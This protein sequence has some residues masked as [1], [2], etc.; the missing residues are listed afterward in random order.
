MLVR[1]KIKSIDFP[2]KQDVLEYLSEGQEEILNS[3]YNGDKKLQFSCPS[4]GVSHYKLLKTI[5]NGKGAYCRDCSRLHIVSKDRQL[6]ENFP[7]VAKMFDDANNIESYSKRTL[8]SK[9]VTYGSH[10]NY[11]FKCSQGHTFESPVSD[12]VRSYKEGS[13]FLG[14]PYCSGVNT[15]LVPKIKDIIKNA[16]TWW[17]SE[18]NN[19]SIE[20][21]VYKKYSHTKYAWICPKGHS[22]FRSLDKI[23]DNTLT[24]PVCS[25]YKFQSGI[26]DIKTLVPQIAE[27][28]DEE[29]NGIKASEAY[30]SKYSEKDYWWKCSKGHSFLRKPVNIDVNNFTCAVCQGKQVNMGINDLQTLRPDIMKYWV[31]DNDIKPWNITVDSGEIASFYCIQCGG[32]YD[33]TITSRTRSR[34]LCS[35]CNEIYISSQGEEEI[36]DFL[37]SLGIE[38]ERQAH[39]FKNKSKACDFYLPAQNLVIEYNG[40]YWHSEA[41]V[42]ASII[43]ITDIRN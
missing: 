33:T 39:L 23:K 26:N 30:W 24:C 43:I 28:F 27:Y 8:S 9:Q 4:C 19:C 40:I 12:V 17:D 42:K 34:G 6:Y 11:K 2:Y 37:S 1:Q 13:K 22:F 16:D 36:G 38:Y 31:K 25:G 10:L 41:G 7:E 29:K 21:A 20:D 14:C 15:E 35:K 32:L 3:T 18:K 5:L